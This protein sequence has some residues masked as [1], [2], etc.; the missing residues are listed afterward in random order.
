MG[1]ETIT[2]KLTIN[3]NMPSSNSVQM[4][5]S[6]FKFEILGRENSSSTKMNVIDVILHSIAYERN[7]MILFLEAH[8]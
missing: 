7:R 8:S 6:D 1:T 5:L 3:F 4:R 2:I